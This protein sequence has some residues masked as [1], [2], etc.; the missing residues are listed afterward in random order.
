MKK[1]TLLILG[2]V[3]IVVTLVISV[4]VVK[5]SLARGSVQ[6]VL[7]ADCNDTTATDHASE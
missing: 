4:K 3:L 6:E 2:Y 7:F 1:G 5:T